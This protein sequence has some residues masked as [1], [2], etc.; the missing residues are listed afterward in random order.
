M[1]LVR[2]TVS[3]SAVP[4]FSAVLISVEPLFSAVFQANLFLA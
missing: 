3:I 2:Y 4:L 1:A